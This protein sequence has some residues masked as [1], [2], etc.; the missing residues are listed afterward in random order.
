MV[1]WNQLVFSKNRYDGLAFGVK[2]GK[3]V[4]GMKR[5]TLILALAIVVGL[6]AHALITSAMPDNPP[7][8]KTEL[9]TDYAMPGW[10]HKPGSEVV[11]Y[12]EKWVSIG[13]FPKG[14]KGVAGE[15]RIFYNIDQVDRIPLK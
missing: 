12:T 8:I 3:K 7:L 6:V 14:T 5:D 15:D 2:V 11:I 4:A 1:S 9:S 10:S 13:K